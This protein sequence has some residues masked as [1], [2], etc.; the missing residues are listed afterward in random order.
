MEGMSYLYSQK[1][2]T[3]TFIIAK[4]CNFAVVNLKNLYGAG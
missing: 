3:S 4:I 1:F 2:V